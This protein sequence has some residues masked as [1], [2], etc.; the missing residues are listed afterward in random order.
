MPLRQDDI[1]TSNPTKSASERAMLVPELLCSDIGRSLSFYTDVLGFEVVYDRP[2]EKFSYLTL[3]GAELMLEQVS[4][5][6]DKGE[7]WITARLEFP[8]GRGI[9]FQIE[10][11]DVDSLYNRVL[12]VQ[13]PLFRPV[14]DKWYRI[15]D[16]ETGNR[17][18][19]I[20]DPDGYLLRPF[21]DLGF[22]SL[23][24]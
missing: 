18:F 16:G 22:R 5:I 19:L 7:S 11:E 14:E 24:S 23:V 9:S 20:Q 17:Q 1:V 21:E 2:E 6:D 13:W 15:R 8:Y 4:D 12:S 10:V 3:C